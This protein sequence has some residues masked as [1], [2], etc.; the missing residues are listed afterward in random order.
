MTYDAPKVMPPDLWEQLLHECTLL[1]N[2]EFGQVRQMG[3]L[4]H[5]FEVSVIELPACRILVLLDCGVTTC[6]YIRSEGRMSGLHVAVSA[7]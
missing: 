2:C 1:A 4:G 3:I 5:A 6:S 7:S